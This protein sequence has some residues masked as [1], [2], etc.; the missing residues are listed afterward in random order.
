MFKELIVN[1]KAVFFDLDGTIIESEPVW[2]RAF[3]KVFENLGEVW[4]EEYQVP[5]GT[6]VKNKW[7]AL[8][9]AGTINPKIA[10]DEL[11][12]QVTNEYLQIIYKEGLEA[13]DGFWELVYELKITRN[14]PLALTTN[15]SREIASQVLKILGINK[16]FDFTICGDEVKKVKPDPEMY[17]MAAKAL[18]VRP[19]DTLVFE[20]SLTGVKAAL[21]SGATVAVLWDG[22]TE[23][24]A[25]P[26][27]IT[28][29]LPD[30]TYLIGNMDTTSKEDFEAYKVK[31]MARGEKK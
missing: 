19:K 23:Q 4:L 17:L 29:F 11:V 2:D 6:T 3:E 27:S 9:D 24:T 25:Y 21:K 13:R 10:V 18:K 8:L 7:T 16:T 30:F 14:L 20:D 28:T 26:Q 22:E 15:T 1:K 31:V 5:R 12:K